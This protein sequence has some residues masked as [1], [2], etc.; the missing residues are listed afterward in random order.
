MHDPLRRQ[1]RE[2][3]A[4]WAVDPRQ[5]GQEF[6]AICRHYD[7]PGRFYHTLEHIRDVLGIV[8]TL[9]P[10]ARNRSAVALAAWLHDVIYDSRATD[11]EER[12]ARYAEQLCETLSIPAGSRVA[13]L[14]LKTRTHDA[15]DDPDAQVLLDADLAVLGASE[16]DYRK[17]AEEIR[18][19]YAWVPESDYRTGRRQVLTRFLAR[20]T[21][22]RLLTHLEAPARRNLEAEIARLAGD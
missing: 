16:S 15:G 4:A 3:L 19:E 12:S 10:H 14:I 7:E 22:Y 2:L 17:Y 9:A 18:Q 8:E 6:E 5:A 13:A 20:P 1:W 11:N 21:I